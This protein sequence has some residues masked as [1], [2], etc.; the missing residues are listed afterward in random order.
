MK[1]LILNSGMGLRMTEETRNHPKCM[2]Q[3]TKKDTILSR[4]LDQLARYG[5]KEVVMTTG[6]CNDILMEYCDSIAR[7]LHV[8]YVK[9]NKY[10][11]TNYIFSIYQASEFV[12][13]NIFLMHGDLVFEDS[14]LEDMVNCRNSCMV[15]DSTIELPRKDFKAVIQDN[16]IIEIG[17]EFFEHAVAAQPLYKLLWR[18]WK[19]WLAEIEK[20]CKE[21]KV[22]C[23]AENA[24]N[25]VSNQCKI[26]PFDIKGRMCTEVDT[27]QDWKR[28]VR[29]VT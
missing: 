8:I 16:K 6:Y 18:D 24:Y 21:G 20:F 7:D 13:E 14:I 3:L 23:Y 28:V 11:I 19:V 4:Q 22:K 26:V 10:D 15:I 29:E 25:E 5:I 17:I 12:R 1:A 27:V 9:N 2:L